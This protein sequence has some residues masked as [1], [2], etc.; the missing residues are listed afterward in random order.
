MSSL[1]QQM[2]GYRLT[3]ALITYRMP[4]FQSVLQEYLWQNIDLPPRFPRLEEFLDY[5]DRNLEGPIHSVEI[6]SAQ[7]I[8]PTKQRFVDF[9]CKIH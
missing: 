3:T 5:W 7:L 4:D 9:S 6:A 2:N 1:A 8:Q